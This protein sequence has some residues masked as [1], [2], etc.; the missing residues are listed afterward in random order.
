MTEKMELKPK[1][2]PFCGSQPVAF[3]VGQF[4]EGLMIE[5]IAQG[6]VNPHVS[7]TTPQSAIEAWNRRASS[8]TI[9]ALVEA[10]ENLC[11]AIGM[12][13]DLEGVISVSES[14][15]SRAKGYR[16]EKEGE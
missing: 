6:C 16:N 11:I 15:L 12:G 14:A 1:L 8:D 2:C 10:L 3:P 5:C 13:W 9:D 7:Y 4:N